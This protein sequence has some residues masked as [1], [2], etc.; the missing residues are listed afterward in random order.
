M[1]KSCFIILVPGGRVDVLRMAD[2]EVA[3]KRQHGVQEDRA[4]DIVDKLASSKHDVKYANFNACTWSSF[5]EGDGE[6]LCL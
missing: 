3:L 4:V 1:K 6:L 5:V 2:G